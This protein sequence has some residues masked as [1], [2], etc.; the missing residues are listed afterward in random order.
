[1]API[2]FALLLAGPVTPDANAS[3][4]GRCQ[5]EELALADLERS[6][7]QVPVEGIAPEAL[8]DTFRMRRSS[9]RMHQAIDIMAP[10]GTPIFALDDGVI[11]AV[12]ENRLGGKVVEQLDV[13]GCVGFYYAHLTDYA[14]G[15]EKGM[16]VKRGDLLGF[17]GTTGNARG[18]APHLH[19]GAYHLA[20]KPGKFSWKTPLNPFPMLV[21]SDES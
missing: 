9:K 10:E 17:V 18:K 20:D 3:H 8:I 1:M 21:A 5:S 15:L 19:L 11:V 14:P 6:G 4:F 2:L 13:T 16:T 12:R 7:F